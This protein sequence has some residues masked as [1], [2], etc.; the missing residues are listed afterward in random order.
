MLPE[1]LRADYEPRLQNS[2][3]TVCAIVKAADKLSA[4]NK[5]IDE[6]T[7]GNQEFRTARETI[8]SSL[9]KKRAEMPEVNDF[10]QEF[11]PSYGKTLDEL[12]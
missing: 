7:S 9:E 5:C 3:G 1:V 11:L 6:T 12:S 10:M 8:W 4:Y 2:D